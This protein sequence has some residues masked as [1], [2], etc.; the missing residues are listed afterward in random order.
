M[1]RVKHDWT[2]VLT[3]PFQFKSV[4]NHHLEDGTPEVTTCHSKACCNVDYIFY[5]LGAST[6]EKSKDGK[7]CSH[8]GTLTLLRKL[9]LLGK[10]DF[11]VVKQLPNQQ[12]S[13]DHLSL[14]ALFKLS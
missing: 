4:Y 3:I 8:E 11:N 14:L 6:D 10:S 13:S 1:E 7:R 9:Q 12:Y 5:T 2:N